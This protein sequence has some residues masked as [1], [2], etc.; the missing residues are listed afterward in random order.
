MHCLSGKISREY[1]PR[2]LENRLLK[3]TGITLRL[4]GAIFHFC[5]LRIS[6]IRYTL[7]QWA[8]LY[9]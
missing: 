7:L 3:S 8:R 2:A 1:A 9:D 5:L 6:C 4:L